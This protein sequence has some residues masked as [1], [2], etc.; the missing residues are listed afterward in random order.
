MI[1]DLQDK[2][3]EQ[4]NDEPSNGKADMLN[5]LQTGVDC[6]VTQFAHRLMR[7]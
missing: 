5:P 2:V 7:S 1:L 3:D 4:G 6:F